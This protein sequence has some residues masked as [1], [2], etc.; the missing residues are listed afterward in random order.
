MRTLRKA[1]FA[2]ATAAAAVG[3]TFAATGTALADPP[4][5]VTPQSGDVVGV[6]SDTI[7][8]LLDQLGHDYNASHPGQPRLFSFDAINPS[9]G[10]VGDPITTKSDCAAVPRPDGSSAGIAELEKN[11]KGTSGEFCVDYAR[12]SRERQT[13]DPSSVDFLP[14][15]QDAVTWATQATTNAPSNL[16]ATQLQQI[17]TC[18][19]SDWGQVGGAAGNPIKAFLPQAGSG[20]RAFFL[21]A[22]GITESQVGSCVTANPTVQEN[23]G[24]NA[25]LQTPNSIVPYSTGKWI[26]EADHSAPL[27]PDGTCTPPTDG[28][29][30][31]FGCDVH[32]NEVLKSVDGTAPTVGSPPSRTI[33]PDFSANFV[34]LVNA[35]VRTDTTTPDH[36]PAYL[37][38]FFGSSGYVCSDGTAQ[39]DLSNYGF[40]ATPFCGFGDE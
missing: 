9:T 17:Y 34:R 27:N 19:V 10:Q 32:G 14:I 29:K 11:N 33:N 5:G 35:V 7:E 23:E 25:N 2:A 30:N 13:G 31:L 1:A 21:S 38:G 8:F 26:A 6:G 16:S 37:D 4:P 24:T 12:S 20:T 15:G 3:I 28:S 40:L 18:Q 22:I 36:I 39:T